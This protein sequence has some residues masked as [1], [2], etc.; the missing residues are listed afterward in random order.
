MKSI[1]VWFEILSSCF[2]NDV[3]FYGVLYWLFNKLDVKYDVLIDF[4]NLLVNVG[5]WKMIF[6]IVIILVLCWGIN[7]LLVGKINGYFENEMF[8]MGIGDGF[9]VFIFW[10]FF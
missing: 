1:I 3:N 2:Y 10:L 5:R 8:G 7:F 4:D 6:L 9:I